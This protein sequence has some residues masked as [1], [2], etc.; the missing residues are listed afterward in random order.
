MPPR[1]TRI[2]RQLGFISW[3]PLRDRAAAE[4]H[5]FAAEQIAT[6]HS[7]AK[8][9]GAIHKELAYLSGEWGDFAAAKRHALK[10]VEAAEGLRDS[11]LLPGTSTNEAHILVRRGDLDGAAVL[12]ERSVREFN[13]SGNAGGEAYA[14]HELGALMARQ[15]GDEAL[16]ALE[17][18][19]KLSADHDLV[20]QLRAIEATIESIDG[21]GGA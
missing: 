17:R 2:Y 19:R 4:R 11:Y 10:A 8:E 7:L 5:Y 18:A 13:D 14:L 9:I 12:F 20:L 3:F 21:A 16:E 15:G 6:R 1:A